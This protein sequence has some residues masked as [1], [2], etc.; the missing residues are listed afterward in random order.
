MSYKKSTWIT[1]RFS[2]KIS[3]KLSTIFSTIF[4]T[5]LKKNNPSK[6]YLFWYLKGNALAW[7]DGFDKNRYFRVLIWSAR[8]VN[9][10]LNKRS[11]KVQNIWFSQIRKKLN[12]VLILMMR[13]IGLW[14]VLFTKELENQGITSVSET[15]IKNTLE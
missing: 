2:K 1:K 3:M 5:H 4:S 15:K 7:A 14:I 13:S 6:N 9:S 11:Q 8:D 10:C 12:K